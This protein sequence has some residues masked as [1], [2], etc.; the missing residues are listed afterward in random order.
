MA[1]RKAELEQLLSA[2]KYE[3][4]I[5]ECEKELPSE[6]GKFAQFLTDAKQKIAERDRKSE[7]ERIAKRKAEVQKMVDSEQWGPVI[8]ECKRELAEESRR[9]GWTPEDDEIWKGFRQKAEENLFR[10]ARTNELVRIASRKKEVDELMKSRKFG[11]VVKACN[12]ELFVGQAQ[13]GHKDEDNKI[14]EDIRANAERELAEINAK[15]RERISARKKEVEILQSKGML[16]EAIIIC[17]VE[18]A[19]QRSGKEDVAMWKELKKKIELMRD[20]VKA[21]AEFVAAG[22]EELLLDGP[23]VAGGEIVDLVQPLFLGDGQG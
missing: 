12:Q 4:V 19:D 5:A 15:E 14:W 1:R 18:I 17:D 8:V 11:E 23:E 9:A 21:K 16:D 7:Q 3:Q 10:E 22:V 20:G 6:A 13:Q 2:G